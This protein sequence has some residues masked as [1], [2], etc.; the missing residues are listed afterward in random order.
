ME[1]LGRQS[2]RT[3]ESRK[4]GVTEQGAV[5]RAQEKKKKERETFGRRRKPLPLRV[6]QRYHEA[7]QREN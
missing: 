1:S 6:L 7:V 5:A 3:K 4:T 2:L